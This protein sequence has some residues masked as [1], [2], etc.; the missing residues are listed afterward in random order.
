MSPNIHPTALIDPTAAIHPTAAIGPY[1][2]IGP[3]AEIGPDCRVG[4][5]AVVEYARLGRGNKIHPGAFVGTPPQDL[6]YAGEETLL[7]MG[8]NNTVREGATLNRGTKASG[9]TVIGSNCLFMTNTH[10]AHDC[11]LGDGIIM[12]NLATLAGHV[13]VGD[14]TVFGG[15]VGVH[16]FTRIGRYCM[17]GAGSKVPKDMPPFCTCQGDRATL[18]GLNLLGMRRAGLHR[19]TVSAIKEAYRLLFL[20]GLRVEEACAKLRE[21]S[22]PPEVLELV[23]AVETSKRGVT[24]PAKDAPVEEEVTL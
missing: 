10:V 21:G 1:A 18:R 15:F 7:E 24:R 14:F 6:K 13:E 23:V 8:D 11:R 19:D 5:H 20:A 16:Q 22:P 3:K 9:K 2:V 17:L 12:A 4:S